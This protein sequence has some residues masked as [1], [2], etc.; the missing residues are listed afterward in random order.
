MPKIVGSG[1][2]RYGIYDLQ[3]MRSRKVLELTR[4]RKKPMGY[5]VK[6]DIEKLTDQIAQIDAA[7]RWHDEQLSLFE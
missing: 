2:T 4:L 3:K 1:Y 5:F 6:R 7:L